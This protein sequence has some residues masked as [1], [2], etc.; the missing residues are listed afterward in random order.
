MH[1]LFGDLEKEIANIYDIFT[2]QIQ[3]Q[4]IMIHMSA[5]PAPVHHIYSSE[6]RERCI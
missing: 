6:S 1:C 2:C 4:L 5:R 3:W